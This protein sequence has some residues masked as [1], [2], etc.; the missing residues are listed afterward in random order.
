[1]AVGW[2]VWLVHHADGDVSV[3]SAVR[4][5]DPDAA[6]ARSGERLQPLTRSSLVSWIPGTRQLIAGNVVFDERGAALGYA[7]YDACFDECPPIESYPTEQRDLDA[8]EAHVDVEA[9]TVSVTT[10][11]PGSSR[12]VAASFVEWRRPDAREADMRSARLP[13]V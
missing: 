3:F 4:R 8:F 12:P 13:P 11:R 7:A 6:P 5:P 2:P 1:L 9:G 10:L